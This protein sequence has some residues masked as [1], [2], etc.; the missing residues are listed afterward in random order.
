MVVVVAVMVT[1]RTAGVVMAVTVVT[2][3][4]TMLIIPTA[5]VAVVT[6]EGRMRAES[7]HPDP[8]SLVSNPI[9][10]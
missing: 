4:T 3:R 9:V 7:Q 10:P 6:M 1:M 8:L 5:M 2:T